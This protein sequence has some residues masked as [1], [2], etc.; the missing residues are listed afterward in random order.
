MLTGLEVNKLAQR[1]ATASVRSSG[2]IFSLIQLGILSPCLAAENCLV[3]KKLPGN[4]L[5]WRS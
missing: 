3:N 2:G 4:F 1:T 5:F